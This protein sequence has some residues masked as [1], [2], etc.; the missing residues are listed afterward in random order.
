MLTLAAFMLLLCVLC[1]WFARREWG[2][3]RFWWALLA[4]LFACLC[5]LAIVAAWGGL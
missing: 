2:S 1:A 5:A 4:A 3:A